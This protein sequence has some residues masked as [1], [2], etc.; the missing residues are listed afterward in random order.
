[1][2]LNTTQQVDEGYIGVETSIAQ[3]VGKRGIAATTLRPSG[4]IEVEGSWY[5]AVSEDGLIEMNESIE[6]VKFLNNQAY[7]RR[8]KKG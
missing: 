2:A 3:I 5:E 8:I 6:V 1:L 4:K 7:V